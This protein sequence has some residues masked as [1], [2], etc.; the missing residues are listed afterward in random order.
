MGFN[1]A[2][3]KRKFEKEWERLCLEYRTAGM[4]E[5]VIQ[6][7][8]DFDWQWFC[9]RRVYINRTQELP[10]ET[11]SGD[12]ENRSG[13]FHKFEALRSSFD[14]SM[15]SGRLAWV[16]TV[17]CPKLA[18]KLRRLSADDLELLTLLAVDG[19]SQAE[20]ARV[21]GCSK[22]AISKKTIRIK[23]TLK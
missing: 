11:I 2:I 9:S 17:E 15:F 12:A 19:Y 14:E 6:E 16:E 7:L 5:Q 1:Y 8:H 22:N 4:P 3:E 23:K 20:I 13:L 10:D 18:D 21:R